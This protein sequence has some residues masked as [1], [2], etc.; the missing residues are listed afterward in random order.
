M[1][2]QRA[3][4]RAIGHTA[5]RAARRL[6][7]G[8]R[9]GIALR[10]LAKVARALFGRT[11]ARILLVAL[12]EL[13]HAVGSRTKSPSEGGECRAPDTRSP[14]KCNL[15]NGHCTKRSDEGRAG[16]EGARPGR[17]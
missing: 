10:Y 8:V 3:M 14:E 1:I 11:L 16:T 5:L 7:V 4:H 13:K 12:H 2:V 17:T 6:R 15:G 9:R